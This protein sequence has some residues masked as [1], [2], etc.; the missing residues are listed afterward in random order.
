MSFLD[1]VAPWSSPVIPGVPLP[2]FED[3][4]THLRYVRMLQMHLALVD[5]GGPSLGTIALSV[6]LE[7]RRI[8]SDEELRWLTPLELS[9]SLTSWFP[10]PWTPDALAR[11]LA[12]ARG[13]GAPFSPTPGTWTWLVDPY[14]HAKPHP[15]G[16]WTVIRSER[17]QEEEGRLT[18]ER[19]LVVLWMQHFREKFAFPVAHAYEPDDIAAVALA[20]QAVIDAD[21]RD[22]A[23]PYRENWRA[24]RDTALGRHDGE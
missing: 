24:E 8:V 16:G 23:Y 22:A 5:G 21:A 9:A 20:S 7:R 3:E 18:G 1:H 13:R 15:D 6:A 4:S 12:P 19:D 10:A 2:P 14:F 17:G 11:A